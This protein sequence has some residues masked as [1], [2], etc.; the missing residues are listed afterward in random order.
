MTFSSPLTHTSSSIFSPSG[1]SLVGSVFF[2]LFTVFYCHFVLLIFYIHWIQ[3]M[4]LIVVPG[5]FKW[6]LELCVVF[7]QC[8]PQLEAQ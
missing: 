4:F 2:F 6:L 1:T 7:G 5:N 8:V 3:W